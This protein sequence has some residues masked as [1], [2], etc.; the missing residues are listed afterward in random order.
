VPC[1]DLLK[2]ASA[3]AEPDYRYVFTIGKYFFID[4]MCWYLI[5]N[6]T[7]M[8]EIVGSL[9]LAKHLLPLHGVIINF[10]EEFKRFL[11]KHLSY[12]I[13]EVRDA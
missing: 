13:C 2:Y 3:L 1:N 5:N 7:N 8:A 4:K 11:L 6:D 9:L 12:Q 10:L